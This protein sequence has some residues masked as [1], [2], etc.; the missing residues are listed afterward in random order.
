MMCEDWNLLM[1]FFPPDWRELAVSTNALKGLRKD[2]SE[3]N[4]LRTLMIHLGCGYSLRETVVRARQSNLADLSDVALL[5]RLRKSEEWLCRLCQE[6]FEERGLRLDKAEG[7]RVRIFDATL[8][9]EPGATG[10]QWRIHYS[11]ELPSMRCDFFKITRTTGEGAGESFL[12]F[13]VQAEEYLLADR[14]Y[15]SARGIHY[16]A[17]QGAYCTVRLNPQSLRICN[18]HKHPFDLLDKLKKIQKTGAT[19]TWHVLIPD[20][21]NDS[22]AAGRICTIRKTEEAIRIAHKKLRRRANKNGQELRAQTLVYAEYVTVFTT[23]P[24]HNF[25]TES[26]LEWYRLRWQVELVFKRFK[27]IANFG[28]LPKHDDSSAKAWLYGKL[29]VALITE[30]LIDHATNVSPWGYL[31]GKQ[32]PSESLA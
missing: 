5:K 31:V 6:L 17:S 4:L 26:I 27:Q 25:S 22:Y 12:Q 32:P 8:V 9:K 13:P 11:V 3:E 23:F 7:F 16:V 15:S 24:E 29:F 1:S 30:K 10:S 18:T 21:N 28:H 14:G 20:A 19:R 2:K